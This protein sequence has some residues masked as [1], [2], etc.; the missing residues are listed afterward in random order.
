M[1]KIKDE[2]YNLKWRMSIKNKNIFFWLH[3]AADEILVPKSEIK[4][5]APCTGNMQS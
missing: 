5:N 3:H 1:W 2:Y 4:P